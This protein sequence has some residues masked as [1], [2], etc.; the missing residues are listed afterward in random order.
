MLTVEMLKAMPP[1]TIFA[2]GKFVDD[3]T[4]NFMLTGKLLRW[5]AVRGGI[6]DWCIYAQEASWSPES[7]ARHGD[8]IY[9]ERI[10]ESLVPCNNEAFGMYRY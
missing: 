6:H 9:S 8:K 3:E 5:V 7:I 4:I 2:A 10:V 1:N